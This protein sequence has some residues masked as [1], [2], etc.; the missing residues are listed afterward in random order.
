MPSNPQSSRSSRVSRAGSAPAGTPSTSAY[1]FMTERAPPSRIA[2][3]NGG[4]ITSANSRGP[5]ETGAWL[6][7]AFEAE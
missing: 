3:S 1:E 7:A 4:R 5:M 6:R 2:V